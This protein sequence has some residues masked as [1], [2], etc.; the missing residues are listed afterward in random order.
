MAMVVLF[1]GLGLATGE[2]YPCFSGSFNSGGALGRLNCSVSC[3]AGSCLL[4]QNCSVC[5]PG[6]FAENGASSCT[7]CSPGTVAP[8]FGSSMC[9]PVAPGYTS[10]YPFILTQPCPGGSREVAGICRVCAPGQ[11][12]PPA[13]VRCFPCPAGSWSD[14]PSSSCMLC[15]EGTSSSLMA[16][17]TQA[18]CMAVPP[19]YYALT[20]ASAPLPCPPSYQCPGGTAPLAC[21]PFFSSTEGSTSCSPTVW[22]FLFV[23]GCVVFFV[24][25]S[26]LLIMWLRGHFS[27]SGQPILRMPVSSA[28]SE[29]DKL[30]PGSNGPTPPS[31]ISYQGF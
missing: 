4:P 30:V 1:S 19:G 24:V 21:L 26:I 15:P 8:S 5:R 10:V 31:T 17:T 3:L 20:G 13:S 25:A 9:S 22:L 11:Y 7:P 27:P 23:P 14:V 29:S 12:S 16:Q 6:S 2:C 28:G 18:A